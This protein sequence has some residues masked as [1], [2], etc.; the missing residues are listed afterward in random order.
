[1]AWHHGDIS[2]LSKSRVA[3]F[4]FAGS[5]PAFLLIPA[6]AS[7]PARMGNDL[8]CFTM[9]SLDGAY[10]GGATFALVL[11]RSNGNDVCIC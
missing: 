8:D 2:R 10:V 4:R 5:A 7:V 11:S 9:L 3:L 1:M 6:L